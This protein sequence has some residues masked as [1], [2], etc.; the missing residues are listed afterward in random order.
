MRLIKIANNKT[1]LRMSKQDWTNIGL[2]NGW[3]KEIKEIKEAGKPRNFNKGMPELSMADI[4]KFL[5]AHGFT[6][7]R[8]ADH[9]KGEMWGRDGWGTIPIKGD[10]G[11]NIQRGV[12]ESVAKILFKKL[13]ERNQ[14]KEQYKSGMDYLRRWMK[15]YYNN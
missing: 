7:I 11:G 3:I 6:Q 9:S 8:S 13:M 15:N 5:T 4:H 10:R 14:L 1:I 2:Q 12:A